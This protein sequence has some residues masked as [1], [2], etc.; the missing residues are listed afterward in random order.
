MDGK[1]RLS[2]NGKTSKPATKSTKKAE[3]KQECSR[4]KNN[5][6]DSPDNAM[7]YKPTVFAEAVQNLQEGSSRGCLSLK[8]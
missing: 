4:V 5:S 2:S 7:V 8:G 1:R 6:L 3:Q